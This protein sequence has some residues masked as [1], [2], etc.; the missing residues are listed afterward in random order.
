MIRHRSASAT[1]VTLT[2]AKASALKDALGLFA[3]HPPNAPSI[4]Y[5]ALLTTTFRR[6]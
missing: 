2:V 3:A 4:P 5:H 1:W 6:G